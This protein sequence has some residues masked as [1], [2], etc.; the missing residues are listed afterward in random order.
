MNTCSIVVSHRTNGALHVQGCD[1]K[2]VL[3]KWVDCVHFGP[4]WYFMLSLFK[5]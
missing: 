4:D 3:S 5:F 1:E 2:D